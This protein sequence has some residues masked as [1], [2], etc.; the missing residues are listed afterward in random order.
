M[1]PE[2]SDQVLAICQADVEAAAG[3]DGPLGRQDAL[4][5]WGGSNRLR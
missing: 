1:L 2:H 4:S 5:V 3:Q